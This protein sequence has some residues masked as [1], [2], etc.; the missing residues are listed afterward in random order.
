MREQAKTSGGF[1]LVEMMIAITIMAI[2]MAIAVP[3]FKD[4]S[5][6]SELRSI[7]N[8]LVAHAALA[9]SEAIKRN[10]LVTLCVSADGATCGAGGWEQGWIVTSAGTAI[11]VEPPAATGFRIVGSTDTINF[12]SIG[13]G[14]TAA[15]L[16]VCR[17][18]PS[19]GSQERLVTIDA[20]GRAW[21]Q[22]TTLASCP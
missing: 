18:A 4:A 14:T 1:T 17:A 20:V 2:L 22:T 5:L 11:M 12:R 19:A 6:S 21:V 15:T 8:D 13:A 10:A 16:K 3:S 9:R 7:A